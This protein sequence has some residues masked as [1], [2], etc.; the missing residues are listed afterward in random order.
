[1]KIVVI[2]G[3]GISGSKVVEKLKEKWHE[4]IAAAPNGRCTAL[5]IDN[6][7]TALGRPTMALPRYRAVLSGV[8]M[9]ASG[10]R[11]AWLGM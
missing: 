1:M 5:K 6:V 2:G 9:L 7:R 3:T 10:D 8:H 11:T 4:T